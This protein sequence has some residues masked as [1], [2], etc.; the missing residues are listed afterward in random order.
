M[1]PDLDGDTQRRIA[2]AGREAVGNPENA[3]AA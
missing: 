2:D 1:H 3:A